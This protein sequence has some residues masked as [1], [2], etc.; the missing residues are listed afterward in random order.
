MIVL[1]TLIACG[2]TGFAAYNLATGFLDIPTRR[3]S[4]LML[5]SKRQGQQQENLL[6]V[7]ITK[8]AQR[9]ARFVN[10]DSVRRGKLSDAIELCGLSIT[11]EVYLCR[12]LII[13]GS[14]LIVAMLAFLIHPLLGALLAVMA[15][16]LAAANYMKVYD[17]MAKRRKAIEAEL[18]RFA[19]TISQSLLHDRDVLKIISAYRQV[20]GA[21]L[22]RELD[23]LTADMRSGNYET[24]LLRF[25]HRVN[26][27][28]LSDIVRGLI[29]TLRGD[30]QQIY[31]KMLSVDMRQLEL[32]NLKKEAGKRPAKMQRYSMLML[33]CILL[34]YGVV[35]TVE[36]IGSVGSFF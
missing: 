8:L 25:E 15:V 30:D 13:A 28:L 12:T 7:Y 21:S 24:A 5:Q 19:L 3:A 27:S 11:P 35:L 36:V 10:L 26:S 32:D 23:I 33:L 20:A 14:G 2:L 22:R 16:L 9:L 29:G 1:F 4:R 6:D 17:E 31:F 18:P 34:I